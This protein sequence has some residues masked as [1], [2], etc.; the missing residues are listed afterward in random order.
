MELE[1][2]NGARKEARERRFT[3]HYT[4]TLDPQKRVQFPA[5]WRPKDPS[6]EFALVV[7]WHEKTNRENAYLRGLPM[8][9]YEAMETKLDNM[10]LGDQGATALRRRLYS[11]LVMLPIDSGGRLCLPKDLCD[12][13][14][15]QKEVFFLGVGSE[16]EVWDPKLYAECA[17]AEGD[18][19]KQN[20]GRI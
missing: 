3:Y 5:P 17:H 1:V 12:Q 14:G 7:W 2:Q 8:A 11:G 9:R 20:F 6:T 16:F 13:I 15:L 10:M 19:A 18:L 4:H